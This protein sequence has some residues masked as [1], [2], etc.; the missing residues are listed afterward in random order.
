[1]SL[2]RKVHVQ[3]WGDAKFRRLSQNA[4]FLWL[5]LLTGSDTCPIP[6][7]IVAGRAALAEAVGL[8]PEAFREAFREASSQGMVKADWEA[9][10]VWLPKAVKHNPPESPNVVRSWQTH[11]ELVPEC[12]LK[13]EIYASLSA[14]ME[15]KH[16]AFR[17]AFRKAFPEGSA[18]P[19]RNQEQ[20]QEQ[21]QEQDIVSAPSAPN[22]TEPAPKPRRAPTKTVLPDAFAP[23]DAHRELARQL[24]VSLDAEVAKFRDHH[25]ANR[26]VF[27]DWDAALRN[28]LRRAQS[29]APRTPPPAAIR[30]N[31]GGRVPQWAI[32]KGLVRA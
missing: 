18:Q 1:M 30:Q 14:A 2:Y 23:T 20:E 9:R 15:G 11:W 25:A 6:G 10:V 24:G 4:K 16:Q 27:A 13:G 5:Y 12:A 3:M 32:D 21:E 17:E 22:P 31:D 28:W 8:S 29:F 26:S 19:S 7:V